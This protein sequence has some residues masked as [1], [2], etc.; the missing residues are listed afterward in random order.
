M[1][2]GF[3][4][5]PRVYPSV[6]ILPGYVYFGFMSITQDSLCRKWFASSLAVL[7]KMKS[8]P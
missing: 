1:I 5:V 8:E 3:N 2:D 4:F 7:T 6:A